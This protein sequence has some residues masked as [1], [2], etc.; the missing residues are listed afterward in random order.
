MI[1]DALN[2]VFLKHLNSILNCG[3]HY[4]CLQPVKA[5]DLITVCSNKIKNQGYINFIDE[6]DCG[7]IKRG[8]SNASYNTTNI[9]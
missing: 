4:V 7:Q 5:Y 9:A 6:L 1:R 8:H 2:I 3:L